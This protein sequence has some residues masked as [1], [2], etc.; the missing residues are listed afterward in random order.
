M[1]SAATPLMSVSLRKAVPAPVKACFLPP[2]A[3][4]RGVAEVRPPPGS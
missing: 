4:V 2:S 3:Y 1:I